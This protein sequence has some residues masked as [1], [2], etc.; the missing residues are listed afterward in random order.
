MTPVT[1]G[2]MV[3]VT[4]IVLANR[5]VI[6]PLRKE[7][8][9]R[10]KRTM[11]QEG[12]LM[13]AD[14]PNDLPPPTLK[15]VSDLK[16][17]AAGIIRDQGN[18][19]IKEL[20]RSKQITL[21]TNKT[22]F[23]NNLTA[24]I[25]AGQLRLADVDAWLQSVEGW[26][27][28]HVYLYG[29]TP[30]ILRDLTE[31]KLRKAATDAGLG[32]LWNAPTVMAFPDD[33]ELTSISFS[34][35][36]LRLVW[37]EASPGWTPTPDKNKIEIEGL[38]TY[39]YRAFR[40]V[41]RR[42]V[43]R[44]EARKDVGL[45]A[46]LIADPIQGDEHAQS[47]AEAKARIDLLMDLA[48]LEQNQ[49][50]ISVVSRNMDQQNVP[51]NAHPNPVIKTRKTRLLSGGSYVEFAANSKDRGYAEE[52]AVRNVRKSIKNDQLPTFQGAAGEFLFQPGAGSGKI[53]RPL[54]VQLYG[55]DDRIRLW[56][57]MNADEVWTILEEIDSYRSIP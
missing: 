50:D 1:V 36:T 23:E 19:F 55:R 29:L 2:A 56:A 33:P 5:G 22:D 18:R 49:L 21:G 13:P 37:Q 20:M 46:L 42:A 30:S 8:C 24:A 38:D 25:E 54:R 10:A 16:R 41:E 52:N 27:N 11:T 28:Q 17:L 43:T 9:Q 48:V 32:H 44:F 6:A 39:E 40:Q 4:K 47:V 51:S 7:R 12:D 57:Q 3:E 31:P 14:E 45:A 35:G 34:N 15:E 26:G 53:D